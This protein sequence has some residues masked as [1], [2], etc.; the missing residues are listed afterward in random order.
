MPSLPSRRLPMGA[1]E[2]FTFYLDD[3]TEAAAAVHHH[4]HG[5]YDRET[6]GARQDF[7]LAVIESALMT[8]GTRYEDHEEEYTTCIHQESNILPQ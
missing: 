2:G 3:A 8:L 7:V 5:L 1:Q 4:H 6:S